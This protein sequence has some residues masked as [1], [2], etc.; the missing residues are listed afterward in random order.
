MRSTCCL[1]AT[2][3]VEKIGESMVGMSETSRKL[4]LLTRIDASEALERDSA[5]D[6]TGRQGEDRVR[7]EQAEEITEK[8]MVDEMAFV[9]RERRTGY[10]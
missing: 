8:M 9:Y 7:T 4:K 1:L 6:T 5:M 2:L 3:S 10:R